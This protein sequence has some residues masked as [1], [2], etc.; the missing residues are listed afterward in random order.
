MSQPSVVA[1][2]RLTP[3]FLALRSAAC[4]GLTG[5]SVLGIV[6]HFVWGRGDKVRRAQVHAEGVDH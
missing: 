5:G 2:V 6:G 1:T 4:P 3:A